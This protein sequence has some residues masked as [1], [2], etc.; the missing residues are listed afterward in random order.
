MAL[1]FLPSCAQKSRSTETKIIVMKDSLSQDSGLP[2]FPKEKQ[3]SYIVHMNTKTPYELYLDDILI[4]WKNESGFSESVE[5]NPYLLQNGKHTLKIR[6]LPRQ[7]SSDGLLHPTDIITNK[8]TKWNIYFIEL[9][10]DPIDAL[11]YSEPIDYQ[12][13]ALKVIAP[14]TSVPYWEQ[15]WK[16]E[17]NN[18]PYDLRGWRDGEDLS[19]WDKEELEKEVV[20]FYNHLRSL[21]HEGKI[22]EFMDLN[23]RLD[24]ETGISVYDTPEIYESDY[25]ENVALLTKKC[26]GHMLPIDNYVIKLYDGGKLIALEI[27]DGKY[28]HWSALM[29]DH[30]K[31]GKSGW[32][33]KIYKPRGEKEFV[34]IR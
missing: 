33:I 9:K 4:E 26:V 16:I 6:Y 23:E 27:P 17:V 18:L 32:G 19:Q 7:S 21:L 12:K 5:L 31:Y 22:T 15:E 20:S 34:A 14:P 13:A 28:K 30:E 10:K 3:V 8:D 25:H 11:G 2:Q 29:S 1:L 24:Y